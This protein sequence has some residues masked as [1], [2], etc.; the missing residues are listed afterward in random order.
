MVLCEIVMDNFISSRVHNRS[1]T[2]KVIMISAA[3]LLAAVCSVRCQNLD[4]GDPVG[5]SRIPVPKLRPSYDYI[6][7]GAGSSG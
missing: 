3:L 6:V 5:I 1:S 2:S 4:I 7:V